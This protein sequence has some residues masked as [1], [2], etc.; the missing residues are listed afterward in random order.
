MKKK[1]LVWGAIATI[2]GVGYYYWNKG[3]EERERR[4]QEKKDADDSTPDTE[5]GGQNNTSNTGSTPPANT[6]VSDN[7]F[8]T[9]DELKLFQTYVEKVKRDTDILK[10]YG[11]DGE[12]G[13]ASRKA[14]AK[15][16]KDYQEFQKK[17]SGSSSTTSGEVL[18]KSNQ[19]GVKRLANAWGMDT[20][21]AQLTGAS[22]GVMALQA[23]RDFKGANS[24]GAKRYYKM[25]LFAQESASKKE[26]VWKIK[27]YYESTWGYQ[28]DFIGEWAGYFKVLPNGNI[29]FRG[30][31]GQTKASG[32]ATSASDFVK[33]ATKVSFQ[34]WFG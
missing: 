14:W 1:Y 4:K 3:K 13:K 27:E 8:K 15:Y 22:T 29:S 20:S 21:L 18:L 26:S 24:K 23:V 5:Q 2:V 31:S 10:P 33:Q 32:T 7:P 6:P 28:G 19:E 25:F 30:T 34:G 11:I 17:P 16:G 9:K 12:W